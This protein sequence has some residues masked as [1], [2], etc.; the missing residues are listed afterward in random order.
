MWRAV[1]HA[2]TQAAGALINAG[3]DPHLSPP[4]QLDP[5]RQGIERRATDLAIMLI[6]H[7]AFAEQQGT[8]GVSPLMLAARLGN[9][10]VIEA[11]LKTGADPNHQDDL[12]QTAIMMAASAGQSE[13]VTAL[14]T[15][16]A[17][18]QLRNKRNETAL[19]IAKSRSFA[20]HNR[21]A[22]VAVAL[23]RPARVGCSSSVEKG[24]QRPERD[25][26]DR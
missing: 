10:K 25:V 4:N 17:D 22:G 26:N 24:K 7:G 20:G 15:G 3:A 21:A 2:N 12:G 19:D 23:R 8:A 13:A 1:D 9:V 16:Q 18:V 6:E 11:L 14:R 5:L